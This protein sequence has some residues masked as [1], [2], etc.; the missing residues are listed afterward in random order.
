MGG[1]RLE[2]IGTFRVVILQ[3]EISYSIIEGIVETSFTLEGIS[4]A[5]GARFEE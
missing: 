3:Q 1:E 2:R 4:F 5:E